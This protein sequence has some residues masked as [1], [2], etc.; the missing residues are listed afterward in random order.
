MTLVLV[1]STREVSCFHWSEYIEIQAHSMSVC[2]AQASGFLW[3]CHPSLARQQ[4]QSLI[5]LSLSPARAPNLGKCHRLVNV[6]FHCC[7]ACCSMACSF[8][9]GSVSGQC[10]ETAKLKRMLNR[11]VKLDVFTQTSTV[12]WNKTWRHLKLQFSYFI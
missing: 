9:W 10:Y 2:T 5:S 8:H 3:S 1:Y 4:L 11:H 12:K 7:W 6:L